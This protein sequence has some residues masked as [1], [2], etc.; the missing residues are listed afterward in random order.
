MFKNTQKQRPK[1]P[2]RVCKVIRR[3][4]L[5]ATGLGIF[6][7]YAFSPESRNGRSFSTMLGYLTLENATITVVVVALGKLLFDAAKNS[8]GK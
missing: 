4:L 2:C 3:N 1:P 5:L 8:R 6:A 7:F